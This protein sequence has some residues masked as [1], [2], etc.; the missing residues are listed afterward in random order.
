MGVGTKIG[1]ERLWL[2]RAVGLIVI[3]VVEVDSV[4]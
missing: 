1:I 2:C 3:S 4:T